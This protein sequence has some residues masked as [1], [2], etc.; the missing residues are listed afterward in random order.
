V[1]YEHLFDSVGEV[2]RNV[3]GLDTAAGLAR[4]VALAGTRVLPVAPA[5]A[6]LLPDGGLRRGA[7]LTVTGD[8][9]TSLTLALL[10]TASSRGSWCGVVTVADL[11]LVAA[12]EAGLD[13]SRVALLPEVPPA[14]WPAVVG[15]LLDSV[16]VVI[17][18]PPQHLRVGEARRLSTLAR[19]RGAVLLVLPGPSG[20]AWAEGVDLRLTVVAG[21]WQGPSDGHGRLEARQVE[22]TTSGRGS[23]TRP[24]R[25][26]LW[27]PSPAGEWATEG[28]WAGADVETGRADAGLVDPGLVDAGL[29]DAGVVDAGLAPASA[30]G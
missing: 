29:V 17:V 27:L 13:L 28:A 5:L 6:G 23:A 10:A 22:V 2:G 20:R 11:G 3:I 15:A 24:R 8:G 18:D 4:P 12:A 1:A 19:E 14:Q 16:D 21:R 26:L 9:A 7:T 25:A 30:A